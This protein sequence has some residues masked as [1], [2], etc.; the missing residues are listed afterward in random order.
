MISFPAIM[1]IGALVTPFKS[2]RAP[3]TAMPAQRIQMQVPIANRASSLCGVVLKDSKRDG[4]DVI[5][6]F[7]DNVMTDFR[8]VDE[9]R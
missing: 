8:V 3:T 6:R 4:H 5:N 9:R 7:G 1:A 2:N